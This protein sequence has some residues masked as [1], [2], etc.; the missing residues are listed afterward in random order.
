[1]ICLYVMVL[2]SGFLNYIFIYIF[3]LLLFTTVLV[4]VLYTCKSHQQTWHAVIFLHFCFKQINICTDSDI[5][6]KDMGYC[7][8]FKIFFGCLNSHKLRSAKIK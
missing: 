6:N 3:V 1:M 2:L 4:G 8:M 5:K 7:S